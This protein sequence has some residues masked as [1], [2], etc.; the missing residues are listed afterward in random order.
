MGSR[1]LSAERSGRGRSNLKSIV[2]GSGELYQAAREASRGRPAFTPRL[3]KARRRLE[4]EVRK[5]LRADP[6]VLDDV[7]DAIVKGVQ[8]SAL[9]ENDPY[10][11]LEAA[12]LG[13]NEQVRRGECL[14]IAVLA[15]EKQASREIKKAMAKKGWA[16]D[17]LARAAGVK[18]ERIDDY[19]GE[20]FYG[21]D[22]RSRSALDGDLGKVAN[23]L[24]ITVKL[25]D[26]GEAVVDR[27]LV[28]A[29]PRRQRERKAQLCYPSVAD[30][31]LKAAL[32]QS[33]NAAFGWLNENSD[34]DDSEDWAISVFFGGYPWPFAPPS[35]LHEYLDEH[36]LKGP[37]IGLPVALALLR[38]FDPSAAKEAEET[39]LI[40]TGE[41]K[42]DGSISSVDVELKPRA[43]AD[44]RMRLL[45]PWDGHKD[46]RVPRGSEFVKTLGEA[47]THAAITAKTSGRGTSSLA[48]AES[49]RRS[50]ARPRVPRS[51]ARPT[52][53]AWACVDVGIGGLHRFEVT[54][55]GSVAA[56]RILIGESRRFDAVNEST[57]SLA[58]S[59]DGSLIAT[60]AGQVLRISAVNPINGLFREWTGPVR[61]PFENAQILA[62]ARKGDTEV[63]C[64]IADKDRIKMTS[65]A[66]SG[67]HNGW[68]EVEAGDDVTEAPYATFVGSRLLYTNRG[69]ISELLVSGGDA[70]PWTPSNWDQH[71]QNVIALDSAKIGG[72]PVIA[73]VTGNGSRSQAAGE[74]GARLIT[75][76]STGEA[77]EHD[78]EAHATHVSIVRAPTAGREGICLLTG[79]GTEMNAYY[80]FALS[81]V[82]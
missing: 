61:V 62:V 69:Q 47:A 42:S 15:R 51:D 32:A 13:A 4:D 21:A 45:L 22:L 6:S 29:K 66:F 2:E 59:P 18:R 58:M 16:A 31:S 46:F 9:R 75:L 26:L 7:A 14:G 80:P 11:F 70:R 71:G 52:S 39:E 65:I 40:A 28:E 3:A 35:T 50:L 78:L 25:L 33:R 73:I 30:P 37:S 17:E 5:K 20:W 72:Q 36:G 67:A 64:A 79:V 48:P 68:R 76:P 12:R 27:V 60:V 63:W 38:A 24:E 1:L 8:P 57:G 19:L 10:R 49:R 23:K 43:A 54:A 82:Q 41:C 56:Q 77:D 34:F 53:R 55:A 74:G 81:E 44:A